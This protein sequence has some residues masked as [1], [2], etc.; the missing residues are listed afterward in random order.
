MGT[1]RTTAQR[2]D[3][4]DPAV[5]QSSVHASAR[6]TL[7]I[8]DNLADRVKK[9]KKAFGDLY[10]LRFFSDG[11]QAFQALL[12]EQPGA[13][14]ADERTL[15]VSGAGIHRAKCN[16][17]RLKH[18]PFIFMSD[19]HEG[20]FLAGDG[21]GA[22]DYFVKRPIKINTV[23]D[24]I[25]HCLSA[26]VEKSWAALPRTAHRALRQSADGFNDIAK[27]VANNTPLDKSQISNSCN[28]LVACVQ[29]NQHKHV[30]MGLRNHH[31]LTYVHSMR[32]AVFMAVFAQAYNVSQDE[33][34]LLA[35]AGYMHDVGKMTLPQAVLNKAS[36]LDEHE[37]SEIRDHVVESGRIVSAIHDINP[38]VR[39]IAEQHHERLDGS[40][41]PHGLSGLQ[42]NELVRMSAIADVFAAMTDIR[43][44]KSAYDPETAF[45]RMAEMKGWL[46]PH[47]L[48]LFREAILD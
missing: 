38:T 48:R 44:Y 6:P 11:D 8:I 21:T 14:L 43:P 10:A 20:P 26:G 22:T 36:E 19:H 45:A 23:L 32:V 13:V 24:L 1:V 33:M 4:H 47:L 37:W 29:D 39:L 18:I 30:L 2:L 46:D 7:F 25:A 5:T 40:G 31:N 12:Q 17:N 27:A 16:D 42:I 34:T 41:Y 3:T 15:R 9:T 28:P 35:S